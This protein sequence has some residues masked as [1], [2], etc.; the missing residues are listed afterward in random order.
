M[1][2]QLTPI[3]ASVRLSPVSALGMFW[4]QAHFDTCTWDLVCSGSLR[5]SGDSSQTLH[6]DACAAG[7]N[8]ERVVAAAA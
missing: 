1:D 2:L 8:V 3:G 6:R 4:L 7:L 5:I